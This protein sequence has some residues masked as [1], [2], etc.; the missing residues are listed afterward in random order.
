MAAILHEAGIEAARVMHVVIAGKA[1]RI[2]VSTIAKAMR[3]GRT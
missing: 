2:I 3:T 1:G